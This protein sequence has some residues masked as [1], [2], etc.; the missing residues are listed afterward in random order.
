MHQN[1]KN[2]SMKVNVVL[3]NMVD[4]LKF[5]VSRLGHVTLPIQQILSTDLFDRSEQRC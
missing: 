5:E 1:K 4:K 2:T 3:A